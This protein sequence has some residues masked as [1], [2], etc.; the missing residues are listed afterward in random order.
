MGTGLAL[1]DNAVDAVATENVGEK[2]SSGAAADDCDLGS[3]S[4]RCFHCRLANAC[5]LDRHGRA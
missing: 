2:Q 5:L 3:G 1:E 4:G